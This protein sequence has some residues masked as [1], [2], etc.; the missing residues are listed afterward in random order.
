MHTLEPHHP[1]EPEAQGHFQWTAA[2]GAGLIAGLVLLIVPRGSPW[3]AMTFFA[4]VITG[5]VVPAE[6]GIPLPG[7]MAIHLAICI[8]YGLIVSRA[9]ARVTQLRA[10]VSGGIVGLI[11][12]ALNLGLVA[13]LFPNLLG[14]ELSVIFTHFA[15]WLIAGGAYRGLLRR[16]ATASPQPNS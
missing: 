14:S 9:V 1:L 10:I 11:L 5:R 13:L 8:L 3:S 6:A 16:T 2:L 12:Y 15:I 4:P 7:V